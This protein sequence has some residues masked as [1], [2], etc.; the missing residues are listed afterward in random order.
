MSRK[1]LSN[2][3]EKGQSRPIECNIG[4]GSIMMSTRAKRRHVPFQQGA[5]GNTVT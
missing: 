2:E 3:E 4:K 5:M 1:T